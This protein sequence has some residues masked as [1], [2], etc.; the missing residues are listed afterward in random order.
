MSGLTA[1]IS[2]AR[3]RTTG[4]R[5]DAEDSVHF[6]MG[7][8]KRRATFEA[9]NL[10]RRLAASGQDIVDEPLM[11]AERCGR[12]DACF[13]NW[14]LDQVDLQRGLHAKGS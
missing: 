13:L 12:G 7:I 11:S 14:L 8:V 2:Q 4:H 5:L 6:Q 1:D 3:Q 9:S 10:S